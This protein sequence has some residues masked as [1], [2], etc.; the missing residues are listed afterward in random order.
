MTNILRIY[1]SRQSVLKCL[2]PS[3][4]GSDVLDNLR[5]WLSVYA[6]GVTI[7]HDSVRFRG[8]RLF[9]DVLHIRAETDGITY[10]C[11]HVTSGLDG[12]A[13]TCDYALSFAESTMFALILVTVLCGLF[14]S[15]LPGFGV[16]FA[17]I[18]GLAFFVF[19]PRFLTKRE[20]AFRSRIEQM[21]QENAKIKSK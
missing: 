4:N 2:S 14:L 19:W 18:F 17:V 11:V 15:I 21:F 9:V 7:D 16:V 8:R 10:G 13:V 3:I 1:L 5:S 6:Y 12:K 20:K